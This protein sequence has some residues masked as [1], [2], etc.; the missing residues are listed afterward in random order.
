MNL[1][2]FLRI[3]FEIKPGV[4]QAQLPLRRLQAAHYLS[5]SARKLNHRLKSPINIQDGITVIIRK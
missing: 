2:Y 3:N 5:V 1:F 4:C